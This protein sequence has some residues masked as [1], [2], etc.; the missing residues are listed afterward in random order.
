MSS[1]LTFV[2][3]YRKAKHSAPSCIGFDFQRGHRSSPHKAKVHGHTILPAP[4]S[5][6]NLTQ[7]QNSPTRIDEE[8][9][10]FQSAFQTSHVN[11]GI[12]ENG[13]KHAAKEECII[14][15]A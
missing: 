2:N 1:S 5:E 12:L 3:Y 7:Q 10:K 4:K 13:E 9:H 14:R 11:A 8:R 15:R 6:Q